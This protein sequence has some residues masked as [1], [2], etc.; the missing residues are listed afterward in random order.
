MHLSKL[1]QKFLDRNCPEELVDQKFEIV[2]K[3]DRKSLIS[4]NR[5]KKNDGS[6]V[7]LI[8]TRSEA[9]PLILFE[10]QQV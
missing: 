9:N 7:R 8:F 2:I 4:Q 6:K 10:M 5:K 1:K 3:K